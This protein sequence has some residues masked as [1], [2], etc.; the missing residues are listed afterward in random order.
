MLTSLYAAR[1]R[2]IHEPWKLRARPLL[3][4]FLKRLVI[5]L[6]DPS[7]PLWNDHGLRVMTPVHLN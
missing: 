4:N 3:V 5:T 7:L 1:R 2:S 6:V